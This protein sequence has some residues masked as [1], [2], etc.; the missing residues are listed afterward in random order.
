MSLDDKR[1]PQRPILKD[2]WKPMNPVL[3]EPVKT[4]FL[5]SLHLRTVAASGGQSQRLA[6]LDSDLYIVSL[7]INLL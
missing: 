1:P 5:F 6:A 4:S 2:S 7:V 3:F